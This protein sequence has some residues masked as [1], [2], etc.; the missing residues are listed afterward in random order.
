MCIEKEIAEDELGKQGIE[1]EAIL[2]YFVNHV[3]D[4]VL[5]NS[6]SS[7]YIHDIESFVF[8]PFTSRFWML[9]KHIMMMDK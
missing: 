7:C 9:R 6:S 2:D 4:F 1:N 8:G 3:Q 5:H